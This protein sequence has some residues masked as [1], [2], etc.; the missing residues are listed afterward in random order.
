MKIKNFKYFIIFTNF[1]DNKS[2]LLNLTGDEIAKIIYAY[3]Q[4]FINNQKKN[5]IILI[6][7]DV[8]Y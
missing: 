8:K 6:S 4:K 1:D 5:A 3:A 7:E 2:K